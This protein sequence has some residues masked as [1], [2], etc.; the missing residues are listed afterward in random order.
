MSQFEIIGTPA[1]RVFKRYVMPFS[2]HSVSQT[3]LSNVEGEWAVK[4]LQIKAWS[5][6][7]RTLDMQNKAAINR[8]DETR[9][10]RRIIRGKKGGH[11]GSF[12]R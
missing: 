10:I 7:L 5:H 3:T 4:N 12:P 2:V 1:M 9:N 11:L 8:N 6:T